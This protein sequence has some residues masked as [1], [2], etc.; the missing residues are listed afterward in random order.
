MLTKFIMYSLTAPSAP[1][2][3]HIVT[4]LTS[5][6]LF[7]SWGPPALPD[8]NGVLS[9]KISY[10]SSGAT[11]YT[12]AGVTSMLSSTLSGLQEAVT[13]EIR[14]TA[15]SIGMEGPESVVNGTTLMDG[16]LIHICD[17]Y[18]IDNNIL[19]HLSEN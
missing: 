4:T 3:N 19:T 11:S 10:R 14:V 5:T 1:V 16:K 6:Q 7:V 2:T 18:T 9:Y 13:Y 15:V 17:N 12:T 8:R